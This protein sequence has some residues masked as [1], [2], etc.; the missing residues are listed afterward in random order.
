MQFRVST[1]TFRRNVSPS[2][3][4]AKSK[5]KVVNRLQAEFTFD[6]EDGGD[7]FPR[8]IVGLNYTAF[9]F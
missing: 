1:P 9:F 2:F 6:T 7:A 8:N 5:S 4:W 3:P